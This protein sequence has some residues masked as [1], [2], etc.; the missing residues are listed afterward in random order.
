MGMSGRD[1][2]IVEVMA[3]LKWD[4][5]RGMGMRDGEQVVGPEW[6]DGSRETKKRNCGGGVVT[7]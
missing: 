6:T 5:D 3:I 1:V 7:D 2:G 4:V